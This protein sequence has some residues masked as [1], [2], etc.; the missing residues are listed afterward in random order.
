M[1]TMSAGDLALFP[2]TPAQ[3]TE[4]RTR[5]FVEWRRSMT[6]EEYLSRDAIMD[7]GEHAVNG[8]LTTW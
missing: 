6:L 7:E 8:K 3:I 4:S 5:S 1:T 2:A